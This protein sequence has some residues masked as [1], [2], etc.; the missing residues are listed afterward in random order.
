MPN[1][2]LKYGFKAYML[3]ESSSN[4][5]LNWSIYSGLKQSIREIVLPLCLNFEGEGYT[6]FFDNKVHQN[7]L[8]S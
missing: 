8:L 3:A 5:I 1:K 2:A 4:N 6:L 7:Y